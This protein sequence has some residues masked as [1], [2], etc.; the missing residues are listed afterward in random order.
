MNLQDK[1]QQL[2]G[3]YISHREAMEKLN[4]EID[5][6]DAIEDQARQKELIG[7][8][9]IKI[10][11]PDEDGSEYIHMDRIEFYD[12]DGSCRGTTVTASLHG[13]V[14]I[15]SGHHVWQG[16]KD[17]DDDNSKPL[18]GETFDEIAQIAGL[19]VGFGIKEFLKEQDGWKTKRQDLITSYWGSIQQALASAGLRSKP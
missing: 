19:I 3:E 17:H 15:E 18:P 13:T 9:F 4:K 5:I 1:R 14:T 8:C 11:G 6:I 2:L 16:D 12:V 10:Y 7:K